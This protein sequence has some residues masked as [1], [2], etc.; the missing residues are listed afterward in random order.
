MTESG[1]V[2]WRRDASTSWFVR[3]CWALGAGTFLGAITL[4]VVARI[5]ALAGEVTGES[6]LAPLTT[7]Q[8]VVIGAVI[9]IAAAILVLALAQALGRQIPFTDPEAGSL[10]RAVDA[11]VGAVVVGAAVFGFAWGLGDVGELLAAATLP[12]GLVL[13]AA[14]VF[15]R[16]TGMIDPEDGVLYLYDPEEVVDLDHVE[17]ASVRTIGNSALVTLSY[18]QPDGQYVPGPRRLLL[19]PAAARQLQT[20]VEA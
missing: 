13:I 3:I 12:I 20:L 19:P 8:L 5:F 17:A 15:L 9:A 6:P 14:S 2:R 7:A 10:E 11:G 4:V 1:T 16:S 18:A